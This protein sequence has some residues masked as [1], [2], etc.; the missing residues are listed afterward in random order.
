MFFTLKKV[1]G[2]LLLPLPFLLLL[3][4]IAILLLWFSR[5]QKTGK[6]LLS[7]SWLLLLLLSLQPV[8]DRLL[9]PLENRYPTWN[10]SEKVDYIVVLGGG[11]TFNPDWAPGSNL[12][13]NSL[14]RVVEGVRQWRRNPGARMIFTGAAAG[15]NPVSSARVAAQVAQSLG[16][17]ADATIMLDRPRDTAHEAEAVKQYIGQHPF[18]LITSAN[19]MPRALGFFYAQGL[20]PIVAPANQLAITSPLNP[21]EKAIPSPVWLGH[22]DRAW[23]ETLGRLWQR[24]HGEESTLV[25]PRQ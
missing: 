20:Q 6:I 10:G 25:E 8:A 18:M 11:Y 22:S 19:H 14:P 4:A 3:M 1:V 13:S 21:W 9:L 23:Y 7:A 24:L 15:Q 2:G 16:V 17:P 5:W 12:I